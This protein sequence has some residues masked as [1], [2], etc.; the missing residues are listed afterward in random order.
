MA[1]LMLGSGSLRAGEA[2][3]GLRIDGIVRVKKVSPASARVIV[4]P[5]EG[6]VRT[7]T[8]GL[9]HFTLTLD[10]QTNYLLSF[11]CNGC[12]TKQ[13]LFD[14]HVPAGRA[15]EFPF[16]VTLEPPPTDAPF[17]YAGPVGLIRYDPAIADFG[18]DTD[19]KIARD[20]VLTERLEQVRARSAAA[21]VPDLQ[22]LSAPP[23]AAAP[24]PSAP[25]VAAPAPPAPPKPDVDAP[26]G[27]FEELAPTRS[28]VAPL[29]HPTG[30]R[31]APASVPAPAPVPAPL[32]VP[33]APP[34]LVAP[35]PAEA[36]EEAPRSVASL[37]QDGRTEEVVP[38]KLRVTT[39]VRIRAEGHTT[40]YRRVAQYYGGVVYFKDGVACTE[41]VYH[42][43]TGR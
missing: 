26:R 30:E 27:P 24:V 20:D 33:P 5:N 6:E 25:V 16:Q 23:A 10:L 17:A 13:L 1:V 37:E 9:S 19:Y 14:T 21:P 7:I 15:Y 38:E 36:I 29:V 41:A 12:V 34:V 4:V 40:E 43:G 2:A 3:S 31:P 42:E 39:I 28:E 35:K 8:E 22:P 11:E 18:Y 32:R